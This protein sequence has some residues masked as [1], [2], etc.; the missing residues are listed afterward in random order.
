MLLALALEINTNSMWKLED[1]TRV[2]LKGL[3]SIA[4][5]G[6]DAEDLNQ[7]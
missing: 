4:D 1:L 3:P 5:K 2:R 6:Y 7:P